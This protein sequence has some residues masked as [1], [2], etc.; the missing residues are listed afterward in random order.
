MPSV[1]MRVSRILATRR[2]TRKDQTFSMSVFASGKISADDVALINKT[3]D[4][5]NAGQPRVVD[6]ALSCFA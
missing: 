2:I 6:Q 5:L 4:A 1:E 3:Y